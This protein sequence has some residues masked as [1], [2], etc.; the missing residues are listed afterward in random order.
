MLQ[1][2]DRV[3]SLSE[4][5]PDQEAA[6]ICYAGMCGGIGEERLWLLL[7]LGVRVRGRGG[8]SDQKGDEKVSRDVGAEKTEPRGAKEKK[9]RKKR[10]HPSV[11]EGE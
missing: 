6:R 2:V 9:E 3:E 5:R 11:L 8:V 1:L 4:I 7:S 10:N